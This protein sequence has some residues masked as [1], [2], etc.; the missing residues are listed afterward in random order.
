MLFDGVVKRVLSLGISPDRPIPYFF[1]LL[2]SISPMTRRIISSWTKTANIQV[3]TYRVI[4]NLNVARLLLHNATLIHEELEHVI[5]HLAVLI[6]LRPV[7]PQHS[8]SSKHTRALL[9]HSQKAIAVLLH[10]DAFDW[11]WMRKTAQTVFDAAAQPLPL[12]VN[13]ASRCRGR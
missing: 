6:L 10:T 5:I 13:G 9:L 12:S 4:E 8:H 3:A 1:P 7:L 11:R 2:T